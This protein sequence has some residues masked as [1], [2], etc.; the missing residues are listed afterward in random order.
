TVEV[1]PPPAAAKP[2]DPGRAEA[3]KTASKSAPAPARPAPGSAA[4]ERRPA[5]RAEERST[6]AASAPAAESRNPGG[7]VNGRTYVGEAGRRKSHA[8]RNRL[9]RNQPDRPGQRKS[10]AAGGHRRGIH[11]HIHPARPHRA[12]RPRRHHL[13]SSQVGPGSRTT[14]PAFGPSPAPRDSA[15]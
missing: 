3:P 1:P 2:K 8:R 7:P 4:V 14:S 12:Q 15:A 10:P 11:D 6:A 5:P 9:V 13:P